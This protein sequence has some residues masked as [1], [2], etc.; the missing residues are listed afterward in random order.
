MIGEGDLAIV[1]AEVAKTLQRLESGLASRGGDLK[2]IK[3]VTHKMIWELRWEIYAGK[4]MRGYFS[5]TA[6]LHG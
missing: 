4:F 5:E 3:S 1:P 2:R 6:A